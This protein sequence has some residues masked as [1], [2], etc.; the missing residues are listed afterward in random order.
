[1]RPVHDREGI[2]RRSL[3]RRLAALGAAPALAA[4]C[5]GARPA[6]IDPAERAAYALPPVTP[7]AGWDPIAYNLARGRVGY[8]PPDYLAEVKGPGGFAVIVGEHLGYAVQHE[9]VKLSEGRLAL[10]FG[11]PRRGHVR[12][13]NS[14]RT[15]SDLVGHWVDWI[16]VRAVKGGEEVE[17]RFDDWPVCSSLVQGRILPRVGNNPAD[18][19]GRNSVFVAKLP[20]GVAVGDQLRIWAHCRSHGE[21]VDYA[22]LPA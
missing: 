13:P 17:T 10:M 19:S 15:K 8:I 2:D 14:P 20:E 16:R 7:P 3:L 12:H 5:G 18:D 9:A 11:D 6:P 21:Y 4:A 22:N 1:M